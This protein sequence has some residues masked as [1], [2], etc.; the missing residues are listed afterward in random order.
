MSEPLD[1]HVV[2]PDREVWVGPAREIVARGVDG[3]VGILAGH[4]PLLLQLAIG[5][6]TIYRDDEDELTAVVDGGFMHVTSGEG[7]TRVDV[8]ATQAQL[9]SE[10]DL[11][12]VRA[13][14]TE[15]ERSLEDRR[16]T[17]LAEAEVEGIQAELQ[18]QLARIELAG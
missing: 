3:E 6:L 7:A 11:E 1:V 17:A 4:A 9:R 13:R 8:M 12:A 10:I 14:A 15:L 18:K 16:D 2:T 5:P